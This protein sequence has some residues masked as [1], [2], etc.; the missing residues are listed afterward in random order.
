MNTLRRAPHP[1]CLCDDQ[2]LTEP[3]VLT[4]CSRRPLSVTPAADTGQPIVPSAASENEIMDPLAATPVEAFRAIREAHGK[5]LPRV[6]VE[7]KDLTVTGS[8]PA[9]R[10]GTTD[11]PMLSGV[12]ATAHPGR[13]TLVRPACAHLARCGSEA[14]RRGVFPRAV[15]RLSWPGSAP[16]RTRGRMK[17]QPVR[18]GPRAGLRLGPGGLRENNATSPRW[19]GFSATR[20]TGKRLR[21]RPCAAQRPS[22]GQPPPVNVRA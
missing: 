21:S 4:F 20:A 2:Y 3:T 19:P 1:E 6:R 10:C 18:T 22:A 14:V 15:R 7:W 8:A 12:T 5:A 13:L 11:V 16:H 17:R 9:G